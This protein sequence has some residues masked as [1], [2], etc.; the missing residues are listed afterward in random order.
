METLQPAVAEK[1]HQL[2]APGIGVDGCGVLLGEV[3]SRRSHIVEGA[4]IKPIVL[5]RAVET[6]EQ[7]GQE[8]RYAQNA[9]PGGR[10]GD[11]KSEKKT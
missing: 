1:R 11:E 9:A 8:K 6:G 3:P 10:F 4:A 5:A 7:K 2:D